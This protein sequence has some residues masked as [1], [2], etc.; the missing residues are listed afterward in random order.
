MVLKFTRNGLF[1]G[2][3]RYPEC[4]GY[5]RAQANGQPIPFAPTPPELKPWRLAAHRVFDLLWCQAPEEERDK[6]RDD[7]YRWL[8]QVLRCEP[9]AAHIGLCSRRQCL[10]ILIACAIKLGARP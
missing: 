10:R 3:A 9:E 5:L 6:A 2:C 7:A 1:W 4:A 8:A